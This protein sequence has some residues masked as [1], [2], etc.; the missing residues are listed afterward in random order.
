MS[1]QVVYKPQTFD[2]ERREFYRRIAGDR[3][4]RE[5]VE[6]FVIPKETGRAFVIEQGQILRVVQVEGPQVADFNAFS[7]HD[8]REMFWSG[9]TRILQGAHL[10]AGHQLWS[11]PPTMRPMFTIIA[12]TVDH[13]PLPHGAASHD[14]IYSRCNERL[15][16]V[17]A[18][19]KGRPNCQDNMARAV[20]EFGLTP[21]YIHDAFNLFMTTGIDDRDRLFYLEPDAKKD[22]YVE[23]YAEMDCIVAISA[24]PGGCSGPQNKPI[25]VELYTHSARS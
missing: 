20:A 10:T 7:R 24:C 13:K 18:G 14:L 16:E 23:L 8:P 3:Q 15:F 2:E 19:E 25:G 1:Q 4:A 12:D 21:D 11:T 6:D 22:D 17:L 5:K 9:R